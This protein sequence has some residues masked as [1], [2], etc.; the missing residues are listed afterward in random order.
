MLIFFSFLN[1]TLWK[2]QGNGNP[3][4]CSCLENPMDGEAMQSMSS[5]RVGHDWSDLAP[6]AYTDVKKSTMNHSLYLLLSIYQ[7]CAILTSCIPFCPSFFFI[8]NYKTHPVMSFYFYIVQYASLKY[9]DSFLNN[10]D[11]IVTHYKIR[12]FLVSSNTW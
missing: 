3:L 5:H 10:H 1:V 8:L 12:N 11:I 4:Q 2:A 9:A 6:A 7:D